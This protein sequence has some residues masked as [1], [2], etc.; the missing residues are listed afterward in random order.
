MS[1][2]WF[3]EGL[4]FECQRCRGCCRGEPGF[5]WV[6]DREVARLASALGREEADFRRE[7][8]REVGGRTSLRERPDGDCV[9]LGPDGCLAY[10]NR[11]V[12][13]RTFPFWP[14]HLGRPAD[15][16]RLA[17]ECPG[18]NRGRV[19]QLDEIRR[20]LAEEKGGG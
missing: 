4:S 18:V 5:V 17:R 13:C 6:S 15:W 19:H 3:A 14:E 10:G 7:Y 1:R 20:A 16:E 11:P 12:Q 2:P 8:C 9:L